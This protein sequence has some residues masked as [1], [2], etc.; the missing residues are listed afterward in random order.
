MT[1]TR[2]EKTEGGRWKVEVDG[3]YWNILDAEI[4]VKYRL[5]PGT[6]VEEQTLAAALRAA[7]YRRARE[8]ALYL[9][10]RRDYASWELEQKLVRNVSPETARKVVARLR[11]LGLLNDGEYARKLAR[12]YILQK[13][14]GPRRA[15][16][17]LRRRGIDAST[18]VEAVEEVEPEEDALTALCRRKYAR[19]LAEDRDGKGREKVVRALMR[20]GHE[21][22]DAA[23]A[24]DTVLEELRQDDPAEDPA[25]EQRGIEDAD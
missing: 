25:G 5:K 15:V 16:L 21:Y 24:A 19:V 1:V 17:E 14:Q 2:I 12:Y 7:E 8:R 6:E 3:A 11:E 18:A 13:H 4:V 9:L 10:D 23:E 22:Y 20:L